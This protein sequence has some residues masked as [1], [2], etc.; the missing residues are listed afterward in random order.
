A[1]RY[2]PNYLG[3]QWAIDGGRIDSPE[4]LLRSAL[5][6]FPHLTVT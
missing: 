6:A 4:M 1:S 5:G 3:W 2:L